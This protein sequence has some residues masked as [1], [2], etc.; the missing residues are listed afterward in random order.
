[1]GGPPC[2]QSLPVP[3]LQYTVRLPSF[4]VGPQH[5]T[6]TGNIFTHGKLPVNLLKEPGGGSRE[7][8]RAGRISSTFRTSF[9]GL[10]QCLPWP[11]SSKI[12]SLIQR[13]GLPGSEMVP[14]GFDREAIS[15]FWLG[16]KRLQLIFGSGAHGV[17]A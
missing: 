8:H 5:G 13:A 10:F 9:G 6:F 7:I 3:K 12:D 16:R 11:V 17:Q 4:S 14:A 2:S 15:V 1:M